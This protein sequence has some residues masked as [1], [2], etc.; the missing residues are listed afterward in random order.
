MAHTTV[1]FQVT[2]QRTSHLPTRIRHTDLRATTLEPPVVNAQ[3]SALDLY[4]TEVTS[5]GLVPVSRTSAAGPSSQP[6]ILL[7]HGLLGSST[8]FGTWARSLWETQMQNPPE[9][10][11]RVLVADLR[12][13]G[14]SP[15]S[16]TMT[17]AAMASDILRLLDRLAISNAV[18]VGHS[19]G[20]K[21]AMATSI[22]APGRVSQLVVVDIAPVSASS[23]R[24]FPRGQITQPPSQ[25]VAS[26]NSERLPAGK[27]LYSGRH[28]LE[29][30]R[31]PYSQPQAA[32]PKGSQ[33]QA[34]S[35]SDAQPASG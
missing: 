9:Q 25:A 2:P 22:I 10:R 30:R 31:P 23:P 7:L 24:L 13:H 26:S 16:P 34:G 8:N 33:E 19:M 5:E 28:G 29:E 21:V 4:C 1:A 35:G 20:G 32:A 27:V 18:L 11:R 14:R 12:N 17:Y 6:P 15:H 3:D